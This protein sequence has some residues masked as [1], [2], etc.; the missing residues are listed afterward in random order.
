VRGAARVVTDAKGYCNSCLWS[1]TVLGGML[2]VGHFVQSH[3]TKTGVSCCAM[4]CTWQLLVW[5][6]CLAARRYAQGVGRGCKW[7]GQNRRQLLAAACQQQQQL[8]SYT[9]LGRGDV[10]AGR[11]CN[12]HP[13]VGVAIV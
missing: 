10:K 11:V 3:C 13:Q 5:H 4:T 7:V 6:S 12:A 1:V 9:T 2:R 8:L